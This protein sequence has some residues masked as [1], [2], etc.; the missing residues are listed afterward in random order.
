MTP[1]ARWRVG[2]ICTVIEMA[3]LIIIV[4]STFHLLHRV[5]SIENS[6]KE[7]V[8]QI[9]ILAP[10]LQDSSVSSDSNLAIRRMTNSLNS[11]ERFIRTTP[12]V[13]CGNWNDR[14]QQERTIREDS[15]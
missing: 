10:L 15:K 2:V 5:E 7:L 6:Q 8:S 13:E 12:L 1:E 4:V 3:M 9:S 11:I 14:K